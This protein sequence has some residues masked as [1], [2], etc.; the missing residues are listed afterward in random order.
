MRKAA[1][2][3]LALVSVQ[4]HGFSIAI[5]GTVCRMNRPIDRMIIKSDGGSRF[6][7]SL[8]H[9]TNVNFKSH[10]Y[11]RADLRTGDRVHIVATRQNA[12]MLA[13]SVDVTMRVDDALVDSIF[14]SH[15]TVTGRFATREAMTEFYSLHL[16]LQ[17]YV[18]VD[19]RSAYGPNGRVY[20]SALK[21]G[22]LLEVKGT[23][24]S[25]D[26]LQ[27]TSIN[28]LTDYEPSFCTTA[29]RKNEMDKETAAREAD[30]QRFLDKSSEK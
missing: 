2:A 7:V 17:R 25:K 18:R 1:I 10:L 20:V 13:Q 8:G 4:A 3:L 14:R 9:S 23:W 12:F 27:A 16:P 5:D 21:P 22:D 29:A 11:D 15:R 30:E 26:L 19:A 24:V 28:I 6:R